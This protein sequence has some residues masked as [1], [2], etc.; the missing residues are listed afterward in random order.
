MELSQTKQI[1]SEIQALREQI[2]EK[3]R[4]LVLLEGQTVVLVEDKRYKDL[5]NDIDVDI[6]AEG[7]IL[8]GKIHHNL[9]FIYDTINEYDKIVVKYD[10]NDGDEIK[11][12]SSSD[13]DDSGSSIS[14][15]EEEIIERPSSMGISSESI[16][17][18]IDLP[19]NVK[20]G[21]L[22]KFFV[23]KMSNKT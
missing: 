19:R 1:K 7:T 18:K 8:I 22:Y 20:I 4:Q 15:I 17:Y 9:Y 13:E 16:L 21:N 11:E 23:P 14:D 3:E 5:Y 10:K 6:V 2:E 12:M